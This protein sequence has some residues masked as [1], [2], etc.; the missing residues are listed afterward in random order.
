MHRAGTLPPPSSQDTGS[1][2]SR[3]GEYVP[4]SLGAI[5][6]PLPQTQPPGAEYGVSA[7]PLY[8]PELA[9]GEGRELVQGFCSTCHSLT[10]IT[11]QPPLP[12]A[13]WEA[14]VQKMITT[15]GAQIRQ[16]VARRITAYLQAH[17]S[18]GRRG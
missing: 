4:G 1:A 17:Y 7:Y 6:Q 10:Y 18:T 15:F 8:T 16:D 11:M 3:A 5:E 2:A 14:S 13:A 12:P 9:P